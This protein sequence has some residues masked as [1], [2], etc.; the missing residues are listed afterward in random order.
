MQGSEE[1]PGRIV[2]LDLGEVRTGVAI[3]DIGATLA[4][5]LEVVPSGQLD[6]YL[7]DIVDEEGVSAV[8][9]G[10]PKTLSGEV[11]F[12]ARRVLERIE[13][14]RSEFPTVEF[15]E[16]DERLTTKLAVAGTR[17][18]KKRRG[19]TRERVDHLAAARML[20]E[21]LDNRNKS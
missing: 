18:G 5:P 10:V 6:D 21:H 15:I 3:S 8:I 2:A 4:R 13:A 7:R 11:G 16:C 14:L 1:N 12:Q 9:V 19:K 20:Q 17:T